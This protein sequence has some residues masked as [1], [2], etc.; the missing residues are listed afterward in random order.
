MAIIAISRGTFSGGQTLAECLAQRLGYR[1]LS[2]EVVLDAAASLG[3]PVEK[4]IEAMEKPPS[5]WER[6]TGER[7]DYLNYLRASLREQ[8]RFDNLVFHGYAGHLLLPGVSHVIRVRVVAE[9][10]SRIRTAMERNNLDWKAAAARVK[11]VDRERADWT[12]F[13]FGID[14]QDARLYDMVVNISRL[15]DQAACDLVASLVDMEPFRPTAESRAAMEDLVISSRVW[16][17]L[18]KDPATEGASVNVEAKDG[19]VTITGTAVSWD[20]ADAI[21]Q[22]ALSVDGVREVRTEVGVNPMYTTPI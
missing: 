16:V 2:R 10:E 19:V 5:F 18:A 17:R 22:V 4:F 20:V 1:C 6:L 3:V 13:I 8:A 12:R 11:Q 21:Q 7:G 9:A 15:G 14:W